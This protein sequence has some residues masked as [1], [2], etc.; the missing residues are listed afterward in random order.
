ME[1]VGGMNGPL[2]F[3]GVAIAASEYKPS[4]QTE[5]GLFQQIP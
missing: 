4:L 5:E 1:A 3:S 2:F